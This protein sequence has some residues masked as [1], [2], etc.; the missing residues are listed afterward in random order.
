LTQ[1]PET[2]AK[3]FGYRFGD[4]GLLNQALVHRSAGSRNNERLEFLGDAVLG[5]VIADQVFARHPRAR[6]GE[7]SR[8]RSTLVR[9]E[10]LA[11]L[12][13]E[14]DIGAYL[15]LGSGERKS[16]G[17]HRKSILA[18]ALEA[19]LGAIY[20]DG[21]FEP[22]RQ[23]IVDLFAEKLDA[24]DDT[25][26]LKDPKTRLQEY[27]QSRRKPLPEYSVVEIAGESHAQL[28]R[29]RCTVSD[30]DIESTE[31]QAKSRRRAEQDAADKMLAQLGEG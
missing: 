24:I 10:S 7:L 26:H 11:K 16:G 28:F 25:D 17:H 29:V 8:M 15:K 30:T 9:R 3:L 4:P 27:L 20:L 2:L 18:D 12:A 21:G 19:V 23:V 13:T 5:C 6:E 31:G 14:L 22:C 1:S